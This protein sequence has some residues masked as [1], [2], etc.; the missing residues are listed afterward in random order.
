MHKEKNCPSVFEIATAPPPTESPW[1]S[2]IK[3][4][5]KLHKWSRYSNSSIEKDAVDDKEHWTQELKKQ[6]IYSRTV[7]RQLPYVYQSYD[8]NTTPFAIHEKWRI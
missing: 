7:V 1:P 2:G 6:A 8:V 5:D 3:I 4:I